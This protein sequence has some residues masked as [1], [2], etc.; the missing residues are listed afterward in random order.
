MDSPTPTINQI[1]QVP[2][3]S[4][5]QNLITKILNNLTVISVSVF[6]LLA[7][8]IVAFF[9]YQNQNLKKMLAE[10]IEPTPTPLAVHDPLANWK[11]YKN[12][13]DNYQLRVPQEWGQLTPSEDSMYKMVF[14][15]A[16]G[17]YKLTVDAEQ[18][19]NKATG[20]KY[21]SLDEFI[22]L[23]YAV[24]ALKVDGQEARQSMPRSGFENFDKVFFFSKDA[25]LIYSLELLVGDGTKTDHRVTFESLQIGADVFE[26]IVSTFEFTKLSDLISPTPSEN[27]SSSAN[28]A[29]TME[30]KI[31]PDGTG[32]GRVPPSCEFAPC[33]TTATQ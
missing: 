25:E 28:T 23:P 3:V 12:S 11:V 26:K 16:D 21:V 32:V 15:S 30:A 27:G 22:G 24:K 14:Q 33:P 29:C 10:R 4:K 9:Y 17:L 5:F 20:K 31:C 6:I 1:P 13:T 2:K 18:N 7:I 19:K 8:T